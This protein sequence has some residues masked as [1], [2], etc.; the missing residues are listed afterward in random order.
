M[1]FKLYKSFISKVVQ[2]KANYHQ[3]FEKRLEYD[4]QAVGI[5]LSH[6]GL[7]LQQQLE[8]PGV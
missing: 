1:S 6:L 7:G 2:G 3:I 5:I 4:T 8:G